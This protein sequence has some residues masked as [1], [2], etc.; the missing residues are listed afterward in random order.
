MS[1]EIQN[2]NLDD[3]PNEPFKKK[4]NTPMAEKFLFL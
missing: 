2:Y 1:K 3:N 4:K